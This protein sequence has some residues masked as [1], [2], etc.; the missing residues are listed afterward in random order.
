MTLVDPKF[1]SN[2]YWYW[3]ETDT[4]QFKPDPIMKSPYD[5]K[6]GMLVFVKTRNIFDAY[7]N[8]RVNPNYF[9]PVQVAPGTGNVTPYTKIGGGTVSPSRLPSYP[10]YPSYPYYSNPK[11]TE[12]EWISEQYTDNHTYDQRSYTYDIKVDQTKIDRL[13]EM[14]LGYNSNGG[15]GGNK[16]GMSMMSGNGGSWKKKKSVRRHKKAQSQQQQ[17]QLQNPNNGNWTITTTGTSNITINQNISSASTATIN[18]G[19][20]EKYT[21]KGYKTLADY[22]GRNAIS[23]EQEDL[24]TEEE[25]K[26]NIKKG[27]TPFDGKP[28]NGIIVDRFVP[29]LK[30]EKGEEVS[31]AKLGLPRMYKVL[32]GEKN[33]LWF[34]E[35][36]I[37]P[38]KPEDC[39]LKPEDEQE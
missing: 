17:R 33:V 36:Q 28:F 3:N 34:T 9:Q 24:F 6:V 15:T 35:E 27:M 19:D 5:M 7:S 18:L 4:T 11:D 14:L 20:F 12:A 21:A 39:P 32:F 1:T 2:N 25:Q 38:M 26:E 29:N 31:G 22:V 37:V 16:L 13:K 10:T 30:S 8:A 23:V